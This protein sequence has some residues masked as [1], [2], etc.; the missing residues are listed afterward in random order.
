MKRL[1]LPVLLCLAA[2]LA[3][4]AAAQPGADAALHLRLDA[5]RDNGA[6]GVAGLRVNA[7]PR[8]LAFYEARGRTPVWSEAKGAA[9]L[10]AVRAV[11]GHGLTPAHYHLAELE[12]LAAAVDP[13]RPETAADLDLLR[14]VSLLELAEDLR[15]GKVAA[16][17]RDPPAEPSARA[18]TDGDLDALFAAADLS[19]AVDAL[20][21]KH[22]AYRGLRRALARYREVAAAGGLPAVGDGPAMRRSESDPRVPALRRRLVITGDLAAA[23]AV[24]GEL[25]D[26]AL[27]RAVQRFQHRHGLND[28]GVV[29]SSTLAELAV[30][31]EARIDQVR[32]NLERGRW[33]LRDPPVRS[34]V[35]NVAGQ[36]LYLV[37]D[38]EVVWETRVVVG[39]LATRTPTFR[40]VLSDVVLNP[41]WTVPA[42]IA[43]E[44]VADARRDPS[45]LSRQGFQVLDAGG[46]AVDPAAVEA[47]LAEGGRFPY[48]FRQ[49]PGRAN[50]LGHVKLNFENPYGVYLHDTPVR[51]A[52]AK[53]H[54]TFSH[55]C[56]RVENPLHLAELVL[57]DP[58]WDRKALEAAVAAGRTRSVKPAGTWP[59]LIL[60]WT[61]A[62]DLHGELHL[63]RDVYGRDAGLLEGLERR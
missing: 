38:G 4:S 55:G 1:C 26:T 54:R 29:G 46:G 39:R 63:Y 28:D 44:V 27:E 30:P 51:S 6:I 49:S 32:V 16:A 17:E 43:P 61:A 25:F 59:V 5:L 45:Y 42:S 8:L 40:A 56:V 31:V 18:L 23:D 36:R 58:A 20:A 14:T 15:F 24:D 37:R 12:S 50:A 62:A 3:A 33:I 21:P 13:E 22:Y 57:E 52:F 53:E 10:A 11:V 48:R 34:I 47:A 19:V 35:V 60:Y 41:T 2:L 9:L 7:D